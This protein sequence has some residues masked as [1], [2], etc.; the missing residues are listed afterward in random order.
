VRRE[1]QQSTIRA[2]GKGGTSVTE[3]QCWE[4]T[5]EVIPDIRLEDSLGEL[6][7]SG[8][9]L[10]NVHWE[11]YIYGGQTQMQARCIFKRPRDC[12]DEFDFYRREDREPVG[13][14]R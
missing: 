11:E 10:V 9:E 13:A 4:Y 6:G 7:L 8:W 5:R 2:S 12:D 1:R 3:R 14:L